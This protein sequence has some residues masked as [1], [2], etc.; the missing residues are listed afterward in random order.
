MLR[1]RTA[2][3][4]AALLLL[5]ASLVVALHA[6]PPGRMVEA[7]RILEDIQAI[8]GPSDLKSRTQ[9]PQRILATFEAAGRTQTGDLYLPADGARAA[10][11]LVPGVAPTGKDDR[12]IV[13]FAT[14]LARSRFLVLVPDLARM[15]AL[16][17]S[18]ADAEILAGAVRAL[19]T[20]MPERPIAMTA[21]SFAVG[22]AAVALFEPDVGQAVDLL[23]AVGGYH[24]LTAVITFFLT[25]NYRDG[26]D[27][28]WQYR[29]PNAFGKW[30]FVMSNAPRLK[31]LGDRWR[32]EQMAARKLADPEAP[33]D[34]LAA[35][36][37]PEGRSVYA[38]LQ[39]RDPDAV[40]GL[41]AGLPPSVQAE[42]TALDLARRPLGEL[43]TR[44]LLVHGNGDPII[45]E[46]ESR[47]LARAAP[48]RADVYLLGAMH[49]VNLEEPDVQDGIRLLRAIGTVLALRDR[50]DRP[51]KSTPDA[52]RN[53]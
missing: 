23:I 14:T 17:V 52:P 16:Q 41:L 18:V 37:G 5:A 19:H 25:G 30:V 12:R 48:G 8:D 11:V 43:S 15:R 44:L 2:G 32:L 36:L 9:P 10:M 13:A 26:P 21:V 27:A 39:N 7:Y 22:P 46:T 6:F 29:T 42:I 1:R 4:L 51:D 38:L 35:G 45:P 34:D 20:G 47:S 33:I 50:S 53:R 31:D 3:F 49:H 28:P 24:D 40:P